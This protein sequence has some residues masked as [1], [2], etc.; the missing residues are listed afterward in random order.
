MTDRAI[1]RKPLTRVERIHERLAKADQ[2]QQQADTLRAHGRI[3]EARQL[4][5]EAQDHYGSA[6]ELRYDVQ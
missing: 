5:A 1:P 2:L 3:D 4:E 6:M